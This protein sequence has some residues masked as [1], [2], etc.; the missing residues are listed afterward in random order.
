MF[1]VDFNASVV[2]H[3]TGMGFVARDYSGEALTVVSAYLLDLAG[4]IGFR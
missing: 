4:A 2:Q 1:K 3:T